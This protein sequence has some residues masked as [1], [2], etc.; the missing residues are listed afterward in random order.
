[1]N[2]NCH[3][4]TGF[5]L[6][7]LLVVIAI[8][9]ILAAILLP[10]LS[11]A[12]ASARRTN[13]LGNLRQISLGIHLYAADNGDRFPAAPHVTGDSLGTNDCGMFY[14]RLM[15]SYVGLHGASSSQDELFACPADTFFYDYPSLTF[16]A[17]SMHAQPESDY[18]SY[19]F[20]GGNGCTNVPPPFLQET[21]FPGVFGCKQASI[22]DPGR[23][24][25]TLEASAVFPWSWHQ[26]QKLPDG[27]CGVED[28]KNM[29]GFVDGHVRYIKM[30]WSPAFHLT[31]A[32]YDPPGAY[33]YKWSAD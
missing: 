5:T 29:I 18:S 2:L 20:S 11:A 25:L 19:A 33:D 14:K 28:A 10:A 22:K 30:F 26:P 23:T 12:K 31:T 27:Q 7:E 16:Q 9:G 13:C 32:C 15:K 1:M 6:I 4:D 17:R 3:K 8:I 21:C 24:I